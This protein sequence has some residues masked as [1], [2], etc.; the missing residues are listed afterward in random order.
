[1]MGSSGSLL[2]QPASS[3]HSHGHGGG[4]SHGHGGH[5]CCG[6]NDLPLP[7]A[8]VATSTVTAPSAPTNT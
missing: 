7:S 4:H 5:S 3:G 6:H 2:D 8:A 1:M